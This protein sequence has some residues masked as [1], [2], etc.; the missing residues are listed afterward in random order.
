MG[1]D[2]FNYIKFSGTASEEG[3]L[4]KYFNAGN[5]LFTYDVDKKGCIGGS[6]YNK[7]K[8]ELMFISSWH[9]PIEIYNKFAEEFPNVEIYYEYQEPK[10]GICGYGELNSSKIISFVQKGYR[11]DTKEEYESIKK[12][13]SWEI[14]LWDEFFENE[15]ADIDESKIEESD[16]N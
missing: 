3:L 2:C 1:F 8:R 16:A 13:Y 7:E 4:Q 12:A 15:V 9:P 10:A 14:P 6:E 5:N 11:Y